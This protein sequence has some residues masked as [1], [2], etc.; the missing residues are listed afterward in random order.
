VKPITKINDTDEVAYA[1]SGDVILL[2]LSP[3][4]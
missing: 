4:S 3:Y 2:L 1:F